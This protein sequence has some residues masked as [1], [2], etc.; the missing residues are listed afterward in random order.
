MSRFEKTWKTSLYYEPLKSDESI[1]EEI[2]RLKDKRNGGT[3]LSD[4]E[5]I[6]L[7]RL[8]RTLASRKYRQRQAAGIKVS[9]H[10]K[11]ATNKPDD[12]QSVAAL[13]DRIDQLQEALDQA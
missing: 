1:E 4:K 3:K 11:S 10:K 5:I 6:E 7:A 12:D 13:K 8:I 2:K 9:P